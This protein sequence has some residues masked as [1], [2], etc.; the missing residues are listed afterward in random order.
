M[1]TDLFSELKEK[2]I[3]DYQLS[4]KTAKVPANFNVYKLQSQDPTGVGIVEDYTDPVSFRKVVDWVCE[5]VFPFWLGTTKEE[6][7][8]RCQAISGDLIVRA[9]NSDAKLSQ[10]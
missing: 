7:R 8:K 1:F 10:S 6:D 9:I 5:R 3:Y 2:G 4:V